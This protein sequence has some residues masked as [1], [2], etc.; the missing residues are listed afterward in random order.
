M[1]LGLLGLGLASFRGRFGYSAESFAIMGGGVGL[2]FVELLLVYSPLLRP[3]RCCPR[4][5][6][7]CDPKNKDCPCC[8]RTWLQEPGMFFPIEAWAIPGV[9]RR[10]RW[11]KFAAGALSVAIGAVLY[12]LFSEIVLAV[13]VAACLWVPLRRLGCVLALKSASDAL[14]VNGGVL[15]QN[16]LYPLDTTMN[17]CP[18]CGQ[19]G[20]A[21]SSRWAWARSGLWTPRGAVSAM[22]RADQES[23]ERTLLEGPATG[24]RAE[25]NF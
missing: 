8:G 3:K 10:E 15:C 23:R 20:T 24:A 6:C 22:M 18:E 1:P 25:S 17:R 13:V 7:L 21:K 12:L 9:A 16:C 2:L 11:A 5:N 14:N 4:C 19:P